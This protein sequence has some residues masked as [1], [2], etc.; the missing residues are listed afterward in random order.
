M[1]KERFD[2][3]KENLARLSDEGVLRPGDVS[4]VTSTSEEAGVVEEAGTPVYLFAHC[5]ATMELA[6]ELLKMGIK[7]EAI[8]DNNPDKYGINYKGIPVCAPQVAVWDVDSEVFTNAG[9]PVNAELSD[10][11][12]R[13]EDAVILIVS[14]FYEQMASQMRGLGFED[15]IISGLFLL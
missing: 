15:R 14:R 1:E 9:K 6:D 8:L 5:G 7:P 3:M 13:K 2:E 11:S 12:V 10:G 4:G